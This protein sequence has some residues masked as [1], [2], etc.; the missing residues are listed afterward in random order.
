M[1]R[2]RLLLPTASALKPAVSHLL[3]PLLL[4]TGMA[5]AYLGAFH[6][7][8]PHALK[9]DLVGTSAQVQVGAQ[10]L[11]DQLGDQAAVRTVPDEARARELLARQEIAGAYVPDA[12]TPKLL[13]AS[14]ASD[15]TATVVQRVFGPV[16]LAQGLPL[17]VEDV[18]PLHDDDPTGQGLFFLLVALTVGSYSAAIAIGAAGGALAV[19]HRALLGVAASLAVTVLG[20]GVAGPVLGAVDGHLAA[21]G[22]LAWLYTTGV[23]LI[24]VGLHAFLGRWTTGTLVALFVMLNFTSA[25]GVFAPELQPGLF[26]T[27]HDFWNGAGFVEGG[28][29]LLYFPQLSV[30]PYVVRLLAWVAVGLVLILAAA[31]VEHRRRPAAPVET[32]VE[33]ELEEGAIAA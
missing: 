32:P 25:G 26:A 15:T 17:Q 22:G 16:A 5:L 8:Q 3:V 2:F 1:N 10:R 28:R 23:I 20:V 4:V 18:A 29:T 11:A 7:P 33:R 31:R 9:L 14:A 30:S 13:I 21:I 12:H 6:K 27:L 19:G 24:G